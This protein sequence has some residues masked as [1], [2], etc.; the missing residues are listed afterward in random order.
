MET[1]LLKERLRNGNY[2]MLQHLDFDELEESHAR[3]LGPGALFYLSEVYAALE[4]PE[5]R[6]RFLQASLRFD[7]D[8]WRREAAARLLDEYRDAGLAV[9]QADLAT[10]LR[11]DYPDW[12]PL[13]L[14]QLE[15]LY[16]LGRFD[17]VRDEIQALDDRSI[18]ATPA[19]PLPQQDLLL[20][21]GVARYET[22]KEGFEDRF[23]ELF[24]EH[25]ASE[26]HLRVYRYLVFRDLLDRSIPPPDRL[27][28]DFRFAIASGDE[29]LLD[30]LL[31]SLSDADRR[32]L[33]R[34]PGV[35]EDLHAFHLG[36]GMPPEDKLEQVLRE[37]LEE[38]APSPTQSGTVALRRAL[39]DL[40]EGRGDQEVAT[41]EF[42][43]LMA[44]APSWQR[45]SLL[46]GRVSHLATTGPSEAVEILTDYAAPEPDSWYLR[47]GVEAL[48]TEL[49]R[50][51][52]WRDI[53]RLYDVVEEN[54]LSAAAA[55]LAVILSQS[56]PAEANHDARNRRLEEAARQTAD[57]YYR[58]MA[59]VLRGESGR[60]EVPGPGAIAAKGAREED[61]PEEAV[62]DEA[63]LSLVLGYF[64]YGLVDA[65][66][67]ETRERW[68]L[69]APEDALMVAR[70]CAREG[71]YYESMHVAEALRR[72][73]VAVDHRELQQ[74]L[75]PRAF[76]PLLE[77]ASRDYSLPIWVW[78]ALVREESYFAPA[79]ESYAG[80]VGLAQLMPATAAEVATREGIEE[81]D[82]TNPETNLRLGAS[83]LSRLM[84]RF[85]QPAF[86][87]LAYNGGPGRVRRWLAAD[88][89]GSVLL[90]HEGIPVFQTRHYLRK[91]ALTAAA[92]AYLYDGTSP[93]D[94][95]GELFPEVRETWRRP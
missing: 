87:I 13:V 22:T 74:L 55:R 63:A 61:A 64:D 34:K 51:R 84:D 65:A 15:A 11:N 72:E 28:V 9:E 30:T 79:I 47:R 12:E 8:P 41:A 1:E 23:V 68:E 39:L 45:N 14:Y 60:T 43:R 89:D 62:S 4:L 85:D 6:R 36:R 38:G 83:Y 77:G 92:Y 40:A 76:A 24:R 80:A 26:H 53:E 71:R 57:P 27:W 52:A 25:R 73:G 5:S 19:F 44:A 67:R 56:P 94:T 21:E 93:R 50:R 69:L 70:Q 20:W 91:I 66:Y 32:R 18:E 2:E 33:V 7:D 86:A 31:F 37:G 58:M 81:P 42:A 10:E 17:D 82:L 49:L 54:G 3:R 75:Y 35:V 29:L 16:D 78:Y 48:T 88:F 95:L 90:F 59:A 46:G